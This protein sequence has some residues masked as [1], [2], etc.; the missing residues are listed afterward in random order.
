M[1]SG[2][3][4]PR[5]FSPGIRVPAQIF[6]V[7]V[8]QAGLEHGALLGQAMISHGRFH[9]MGGDELLAQLGVVKLGSRDQ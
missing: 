8:G 3:P 7:Q 5:P 6:G 2:Y 9:L 1:S 4:L